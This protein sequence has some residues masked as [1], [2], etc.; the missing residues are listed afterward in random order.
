MLIC[1]P[2]RYG[3]GEIGKQEPGKGKGTK[4]AVT[5]AGVEDEMTD[6]GVDGTEK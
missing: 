6:V 3:A 1:N 2:C 5:A 4:E